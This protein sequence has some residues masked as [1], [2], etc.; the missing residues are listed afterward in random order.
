MITPEQ[1]Q[2]DVDIKTI[3]G[4]K[5]TLLLVNTVGFPICRHI[6]VQKANVVPAKRYQ[7]HITDKKCLEL[8][9]IEKGKHKPT[10]TR[11]TEAELVI[12]LGWQEIQTATNFTIFED[13][14]LSVMVTQAKDIVYT[15]RNSWSK[16][17]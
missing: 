12:A 17:E 4:K 5:V 3:E 14:L 10:G 1:P 6:T 9:Y 7:E 15:Q 11:Y 13:T 16:T 8:Q 2:S